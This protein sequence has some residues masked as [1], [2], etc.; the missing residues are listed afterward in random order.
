MR[1]PW[2]VLAVLAI[3]IVNPAGSRGEEAATLADAVAPFVDNQTVAIVHVD[4][5]AFDAA[6]AVDLLA[7]FFNLPKDRRDRI[8]A[9]IVPLNV[10]ADSLPE[11]ARADMFMI[12]SIADIA[13][14]PAFFVLPPGTEAAGPIS[15][16][17]KRAIEKQTSA[18]LATEQIGDSQVTGSVQTIARLKKVPAVKRPEIAAAFDA[19][20]TGA[21]Q[22]LFVPAPPALRAIEV[23]LPKLPAQLGG[24]AT[25]QFTGNLAWLAVR[26][27]LPP[28][29]TRFRMV[30][31]ATGAEGAVALE[32]LLRK[33]LD[34]LVAAP[35]IKDAV[36][37]AQELAKGLVP[38]LAE[39]RLTLELD[40]DQIGRVQPLLLALLKS[41]ERSIKLPS[42]EKKPAEK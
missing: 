12:S 42:L 24:G 1:R 38:K 23:L 11:G 15:L 14:L 16:E 9:D 10:V 31:Q 36:P 27:D 3:A 41:A 8:Q 29:P 39:S 33:T 35:E 26:I 22:I 5:A 40:G 32:A 7:D 37:E 6:Q 4:L 13:T 18:K 34:D 2:F 19:V 28:Q 30:I 17:L 25:K 20:G 21:L